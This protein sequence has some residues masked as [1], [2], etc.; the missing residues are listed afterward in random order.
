MMGTGAMGQSFGLESNLSNLEGLREQL[1]MLEGEV[2]GVT[3]GGKDSQIG[4]V[5]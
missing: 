5:G 3:G 2:G 4:G 1:K